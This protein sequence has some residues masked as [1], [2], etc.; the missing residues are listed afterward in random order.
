MSQTGKMIV[1]A[2]VALVLG[3]VVGHY[4]MVPTCP[5][6]GEP[7]TRGGGGVAPCSLVQGNPPDQWPTVDCGDGTGC[8]RLDQLWVMAN[9]AQA[10]G[11]IPA[12]L[13]QQIIDKLYTCAQLPPIEPPEPGVYQPRCDSLKRALQDAAANNW[14]A[15]L[16]DIPMGE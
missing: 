4:V 16:Q 7:P 5:T 12:P 14:S 2:V 1:A 6:P 10:T 13:Y 8:S 11:E 9:Q 15:V 3:F